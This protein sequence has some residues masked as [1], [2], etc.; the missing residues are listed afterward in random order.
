M[1]NT[2]VSIAT[3]IA[4]KGIMI[5]I[6]ALV[7]LFLYKLIKFFDKKYLQACGT[8]DV[9]LN[10][11]I[12]FCNINYA[13][14]F[15]IPN[16]QVGSPVR[17]RMF[18]DILQV[19]L[20]TLQNRVTQ[21]VNETY[22]STDELQADI[23]EGVNES[24]TYYTAKWTT[25]GVP[26]VVIGKVLEHCDRHNAML[27]NAT[28]QV[29]GSSV[30]STVEKKKACLLTILDCVINMYIMDVEKTFTELNGSIAQERYKGELIGKG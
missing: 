10:N 7:I 19:K 15:F 20:S 18:R 14:K 17:S 25:L 13:L 24:Y 9:N 29:C 6:S 3:L 1:E 22:A 21:M 8:H 26:D 16:L 11:H 27:I 12:F 28:K 4:D 5:V 30:F 23:L 2:L